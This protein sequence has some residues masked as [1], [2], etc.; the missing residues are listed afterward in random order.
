MIFFVAEIRGLEEVSQD[1]KD[2][3]EDLSLVPKNIKQVQFFLSEDAFFEVGLSTLAPE[4]QLTLHV[5]SKRCDLKTCYLLSL[6][7]PSQSIFFIVRY[8]EPLKIM[9][10]QRDILDRLGDRRLRGR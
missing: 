10:D 4:D 6:I 2:R 3:L 7:S 1:F 9:A 5:P 8:F